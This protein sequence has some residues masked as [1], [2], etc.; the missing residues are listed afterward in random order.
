MHLFLL[1]HCFGCF[2]SKKWKAK[3]CLEMQSSHKRTPNVGAT[4][5][6]IIAAEKSQDHQ[7]C[8]GILPVVSASL[9]PPALPALFKDTVSKTT[10]L[11]PFC[12]LPACWL[13][14]PWVFKKLFTYLTPEQ[15]GGI[16]VYVFLSVCFPHKFS[17]SNLSINPYKSIQIQFGH[18][19]ILGNN[20]G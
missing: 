4:I 16:S 13:Q 7:S 6:E 5:M 15:D 12:S 20:P 19:H 2:L 18:L 3:N 10:F 8:E 1:L 11:P 14:A 17:L 9:P